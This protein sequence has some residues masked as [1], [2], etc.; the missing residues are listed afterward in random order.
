MKN[1]IKKIREENGYTQS[2]FADALMIS[3]SAVSKIESGENSPSEQ[4][5]EIICRDFN[6]NKNW[7]K[8]GE[9]EK[10]AIEE[11]E[12]AAY[13][14][15]LL[16]SVDDPIADAIADFMKVYLECD[17]KDRIVLQNFAKRLLEIKKQK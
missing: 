10:Y 11:D 9:G 16:E 17:Y 13:V 2:A 5:I 15:Y 4:T 12:R 7:L 3:R 14:S 1:R 8:T 6:I